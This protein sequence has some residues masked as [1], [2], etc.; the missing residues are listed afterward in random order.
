M[1]RL[2][3]M[4]TVIGYCRR[5]QPWLAPTTMPLT[6]PTP[7]GPRQVL[8]VRL[9]PVPPAGA[10]D[11]RPDPTVP[12]GCMEGDDLNPPVNICDVENPVVAISYAGGVSAIWAVEPIAPT[13]AQ[14]CFGSQLDTFANN[15]TQSSDATQPGWRCIAIATGDLNGNLSTSRRPGQRGSTTRMLL[16]RTSATRRPPTPARLRAA[17]GPTTRRPTRC[18]PRPARRGSFRLAR[19]ASTTTA[20][21]FP[22]RLRGA[23]P[24]GDAP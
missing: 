23:L 5:H 22:S 16:R 3:T 6:G 2:S 24:D 11:F 8:K 18:R 9:K 12:A 17:R 1:L 4:L 15:V 19:S 13:D 14:Y 20:I 21:E 10:A 7:A